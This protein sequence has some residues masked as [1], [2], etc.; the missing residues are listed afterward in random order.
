MAQGRALE[1][2]ELQEASAAGQ[3]ERFRAQG[4]GKA[5]ALKGDVEAWQQAGYPMAA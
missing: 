5:R 1:Q 3:A 2:V 4:F